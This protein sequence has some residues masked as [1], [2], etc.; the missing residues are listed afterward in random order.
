MYD[1]FNAGI[2][3]LLLFVIGN[4]AKLAFTRVEFFT[5]LEISIKRS[6]I[7]YL[8]PGHVH[9]HFFARLPTFIQLSEH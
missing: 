6:G 8:Q 7:C 5:H 1:L 3:Y 4:L 9:I 2:D